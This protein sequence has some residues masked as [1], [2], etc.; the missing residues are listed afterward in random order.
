M[1]SR[2][3]AVL[4]VG[5]L[6]VAEASGAF[7][8]AA[9]LAG[10]S[11]ENNAR[12]LVYFNNENDLALVANGRMVP[13]GLDTHLWAPESC[14]AHR[15]TPALSGDGSRVAFVHLASKQ[16]HREAIAI[17]DTATRDQKDVFTA[18]AVWGIA[19]SPEGSR[20]AVV[21]DGEADPGHSLYVVDLNSDSSRPLTRGN[22]DLGGVKYAV[23]DYA[24]PSWASSGRELAFE[25]RRKGEAA[26]A[27]WELESSRLRKLADGVEP[28]WSPAGD[29]IAF[30]DSV[31]Q[32]CFS[33]RPDGREKSLL[34]S[35]T[36]GFLGAGGAAPL[37]FPVVWSPDGSRLL[38]H[39]W[40]DADLLTEIYMR[41][42]KTGKVK[43]VGRSEL[44]VVNWR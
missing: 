38:W 2:F 42:L 5:S 16:P 6:L 8:G 29:R 20:L 13:L 39:E 30:F 24:P 10:F 15:A 21:A 27:V 7:H 3:M 11:K 37:F 22:V 34:F 31:R 19:W 41:D 43:H 17:Y 14:C 40:N 26:I 23:S 35:A 4:L 32:S 44:Q 12:I 28:S 25:V 36:R 33:I 1:K 18:Q 9:R